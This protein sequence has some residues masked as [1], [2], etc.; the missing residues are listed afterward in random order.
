MTSILVSH[1][2]LQD[3]LDLP[4]KIKAGHVGKSDLFF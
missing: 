2:I 4:V 1:L 3:D